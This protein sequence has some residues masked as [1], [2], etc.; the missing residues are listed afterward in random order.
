[1]PINEFMGWDTSNGEFGFGSNVSVTN[2]VVTFTEYGNIRANVVYGNVNGTLITQ[3]QPNI[4]SVGTLSTLSVTNWANIGGEA[5]VNTLKA[6][7][8]SYPT[9]D[10]SAGQVLSTYGNGSLYFTTIDT[11]RIQNGTSNVNVK[12]NGNVEFVVGGTSIANVTS[13]GIVITGNVTA[14]NA[15]VTTLVIGNSQV[16]SATV[17]TSSTSQATLVSLA[18]ADFR[19]AEFFVKGEDSTGSKYSVATV[20]MVHDATSAD[21]SVYGTV[22]LPSSST[23][24]SLGVTYASSIANLVVTPSSSNT[25][26]WTIQYRTM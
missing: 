22:N 3:A 19:V 17:V 9:S 20:S 13:S 6:S 25:T 5:N 18:G 2:E 26:T 4:T 1:M 16:R 8:L 15:N 24:G 23:T 14:N 10:G 7:G 12:N 11:Y 21:Y